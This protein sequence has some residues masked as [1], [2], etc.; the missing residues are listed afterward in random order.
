MKCKAIIFNK[1]W[2]DLGLLIIRVGIGIMFIM[3][4][5]P[6]ITGGVAVWE[7]LGMQMGNIGIGFAPVFWG[8]MAALAEFGGGILLITGLLTRPAAFGMFFTMLIAALMH[9][10]MGEGIKGSAHA[11]ELGIVFLAL[12]FAGG[13]K[14]SLDA[15]LGKRFC[16]GKALS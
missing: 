15:I 14:Y 2:P 10:S 6:K 11:I 1:Q 7:F 3:H 4:G 13:G 8:F 12:M 16:N 9:L 5:Y